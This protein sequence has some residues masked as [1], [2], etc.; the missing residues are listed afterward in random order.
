MVTDHLLRAIIDTAID[1]FILIDEAGLKGL[2]IGSAEVSPKHANFIQ[3]DDPGRAADV[4]ALMAEV[5]RRVFEHAG[6]ALHPETVT[7]GLPPLPE[8]PS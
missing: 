7:V 8:L 2:R 5:R 4:W 3:V 6:V 1:G